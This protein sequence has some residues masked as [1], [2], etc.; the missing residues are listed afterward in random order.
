MNITV[1]IF[2]LTINNFSFAQKPKHAKNGFKIHTFFLSVVSIH[3]KDLYLCDR[4]VR[5]AMYKQTNCM[6]RE[7]HVLSAYNNSWGLIQ[8]LWSLIFLEVRQ[9][10]YG[11]YGWVICTFQQ[12]QIL[13]WINTRVVISFC[14]CV[15]V[16]VYF[17]ALDDRQKKWQGP[18]LSDSILYILEIH[19]W[20]NWLIKA[21]LNARKCTVQ[22]QSWYWYTVK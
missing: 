11:L 9:P 1:V 6:Q 18:V 12:R 20:N 4:S 15:C 7:V 16:C 21:V 10:W 14:V 19:N 13:H 8:L 2:N 17:L 5:G 3:I 22:V